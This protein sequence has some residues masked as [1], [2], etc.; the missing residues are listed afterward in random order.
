MSR[1]SRD[2]EPKLE[3]LRSNIWALCEEMN[4]VPTWQQAQ[5]LDIVQREHDLPFEY[6]KQRI[7][8]KS[9]QGPGKTTVMV[10]IAIFRFLQGQDSLVIMT[11]P[12]MRQCKDVFLAEFR[13]RLA[14][15]SALLQKIIKVTTTRVEVCGRR[16]WGVWIAT[17]SKPVN[18]QGYHQKD[19]TFLVDEASGVERASVEQIKNTLTNPNALLAMI[20]NPNSM[21]CPLYDCFTSEKKQWHLLTWSAEDTARIV[22][23]PD[24][25]GIGIRNRLCALEYGIDSDVY[26]IRVQGEF[27]HHNP[28]SIITLAD[29]E[30]AIGNSMVACSRKRGIL[31]EDKVLS[32]DFAR[33]GGD[34]NVLFRRSGLAIVEH[35]EQ[36]HMDPS[37]LVARGFK[38]QHEASWANDDCWHVGDAT[39]L[40]GGVMHIFHDAGKQVHEFHNGGSSSDPQFH[41][42][43]TEAWFNCA[44][45]LRSGEIY[46]PNDN[47]LVKQLTTRW[48]HTTAKDGK[49]IVEAKDDYIKRG[50][51]SPDRADACVMAFYNRLKATATLSREVQANP[52]LGI[53]KHRHQ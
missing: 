32:Y 16:D 26:R 11:A 41:N 15:A 2:L 27:P 49:L 30:R 3:L 44:K 18:L 5:A 4:F 19:L 7:A 22:S 50:H 40:G 48:Y 47:R 33:F 52:Q 51:D 34:E 14:K 37:R 21:D 6:R 17:S 10:I 45:L 12:T 8:I 39:G 43:I 42:K 29:L 9:G 13:R 20:G 31:A 25:I 23:H 36:A 35:F 24:H 28:Q 53:R 38:M 46:L 1:L